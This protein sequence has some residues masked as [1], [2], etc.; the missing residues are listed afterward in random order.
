MSNGPVKPHAHPEFGAGIRLRRRTYNLR[1]TDVTSLYFQDLN[2]YEFM[3]QKK[4]DYLNVK[5]Q[6]DL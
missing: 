4:S 1:T 6:L 3:L 5:D 2:D